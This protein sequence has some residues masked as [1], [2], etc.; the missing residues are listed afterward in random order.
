MTNI[1]NE[2]G[3]D[4]VAEVDHHDHVT[5]PNEKSSHAVP[6]G[7]AHVTFKVWIVVCIMSWGYGLSFIPVP[8]FAAVGTEI[9]TDL[10]NAGDSAWFIPAWIISIT[11]AFMIAGSNTDM[12]GRRWFL[13]TGQVVCFVGH[14]ITGL[15]KS[16]AQI[17]AGMTIEGFGAALCQM[18]A[19]ALPELLPNKWRAI[20]VVLADFAVYLCITVIPVTARYGYFVGDWRA[21][22][23]SAAGLQALSAAGLYFFYYPPAHPLGIPFRTAFKQLDYLGMLLFT[24]G[25]VPVMV[26]I[27]YT[28]SVPASDPKVLGTLIAGFII[29]VLFGVWETFGHARHPLT[30][31]AIFRKGRGRDFTAPCIALAIINMFYY[32]SSIIWPTMINAFYTA[33]GQPWERAAVLS[34]PQ[35]LAI[36]GGAIG[37]T[38]LGPLIK[39]YHWQQTASVTMMVVFGSLLA[40]A[41]PTNMGLMCTFVV[42]SLFGYGWAIYLSIAFTQLGVDQEN[43][44]ISGERLEIKDAGVR[45]QGRRGGRVSASQIPDLLMLLAT[46]K[47]L[48]SQFG[49]SVAGAVGLAQQ[50]AIAHGIKL[51]ALTSLGFGC[52]G[53]VACL[54]CQ[55]IDSRM[56]NTIEVF[57]ENDEFADR[58]KFH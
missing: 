25:A 55:N 10:G 12:L 58:N 54:C 38:F 21:N 6:Q 49:E 19:F 11:T 43:L 42:L 40:L 39:H 18:A 23:Y 28:A 13:I 17:I 48:A 22:F 4:V 26:G 14:L 3:G 1:A 33:G 30:P 9:A 5:T 20:G 46:P 52:I 56:D 31:P 47:E 44:G 7:D 50:L 57:L 41:T 37:L 35:G 51:I 8:L 24:A 34:L 45:D 36:T 2:K 27:V 53:I 16:N 32:S 29:L 15:A